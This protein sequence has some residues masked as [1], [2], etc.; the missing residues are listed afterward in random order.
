MNNKQVWKWVEKIEK[1]N[2]D[3][4]KKFNLKAILFAMQYLV[5]TKIKP[6]EFNKVFNRFIKKI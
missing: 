2:I 4:F 1:S 6:T 5:E 3:E